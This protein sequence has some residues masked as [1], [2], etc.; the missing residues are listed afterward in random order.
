M[1]SHQTLASGSKTE[2]ILSCLRSKGTASSSHP[3]TLV[4]AQTGDP[5]RTDLADFND[6]LAPQAHE[7]FVNYVTN[8]WSFLKVLIGKHFTL[9]M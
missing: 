7:H 1:C 8:D 5:Q 6:F 3:S 4:G 2:F 9:G